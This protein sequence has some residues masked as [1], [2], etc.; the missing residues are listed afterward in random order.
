MPDPDGR[1]VVR[2][3][4]ARSLTPTRWTKPRIVSLK[5]ALVLK[6]GGWIIVGPDPNDLIDLA[7]WEKQQDRQAEWPFP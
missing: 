5:R 6:E 2:C 3:F 4:A 1:P 7:T